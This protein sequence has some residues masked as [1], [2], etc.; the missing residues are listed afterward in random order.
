MASVVLGVASSHTPQLNTAPSWWHDHAGRDRDNKRLLGHD[1][2]FRTYDELLASQTVNLATELTEEVW[3]AKHDRSQAAIAYLRDQLC[4]AEPDAVIILGDDQDEMFLNDGVPTFGIFAG[5]CVVDKPHLPA[6][7]KTLRD[8]Q[9]AALWA[10]HGEVDEQYPVASELGMHLIEQLMTSE[11]DVSYYRDQPSG[12]SIGH[13]FTFVR[14]RL[15]GD[16]AIPI[17]PISV[18]TYAPPNQPTPARCYDF[19][20]AIADAVSSFPEDMRVAVVASGGLSHFVIDEKLDRDV[21]TALGQNDA[22]LLGSI[23]RKLLRSGTSE[24]LNWIAAG[25]ALR[26]LSMNVV[27]YVAAYRSPAGTGVG[28]GFALWS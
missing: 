13:A 14:R 16:T 1:G 28:M 22:A 26:G 2:Q 10:V 21:L 17:V 5:S 19:G 11:F 4:T 20:R 6:K 27:D 18:N 25:G 12:R 3:V 8:G 15:M 7:M 24:V 9:K 23:P